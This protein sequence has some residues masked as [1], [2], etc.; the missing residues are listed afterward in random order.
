M[1]SI[2]NCTYTIFSSVFGVIADIE[3]RIVVLYQSLV[4]EM[5]QM[6]KNNYATKHLKK[7]LKSRRDDDDKRYLLEE[8]QQKINKL[9][10]NNRY[11][12][13]FYVCDCERCLSNK[14]AKVERKLIAVNEQLMEFKSGELDMEEK[15]F[16]VEDYINPDVEEVVINCCFGGFSL[17]DKA[18]QLLADLTG[19]TPDDHPDIARN[20][21]RLVAIVKSLGEDAASGR[22]A[23]LNVVELEKGCKW[24]INEYDGWETIELLPQLWLIT[25]HGKSAVIIANSPSE[26]T[27]KAHFP[28]TT[29]VVSID[30]GYLII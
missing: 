2:N 8:Y 10:K 20:D 25:H 23:S 11:N 26:A 7:L 17:S 29:A 27:K 28:D 12:Q 22:C 15:E 9:Y 13:I 24:R 1:C 30:D 14:T 18:A 5:I 3:Q 19:D 16:R 6:K 21:K 4:K